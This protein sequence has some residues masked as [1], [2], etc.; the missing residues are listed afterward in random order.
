M[1]LIHLI[2]LPDGWPFGNGKDEPELTIR[3]RKTRD[4][5]RFEWKNNYYRFK[6]TAAAFFYGSQF[7]D[8][9][10]DMKEYYV[11]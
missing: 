5:F 2:R 6:L 11:I 9:E 8:T 10:T 7:S 3:S 4:S 1:S